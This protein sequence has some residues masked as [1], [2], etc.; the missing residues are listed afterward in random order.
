VSPLRTLPESSHA[1]QRKPGYR[2]VLR[3]WMRFHAGAQ[4][5][6]DAADDLFRAGQRNV[7]TLYE[8]WLFFQLLDWFC[9]RFDVAT[10]PVQSL[11]KRAGDGLRCALRQGMALGPFEGI[12]G[13]MRA[14]FRYNHT[15]DAGN[16]GGSWTR[17]MR[18]DFTL[19]F[20]RAD[21][22]SAPIHLHFDAKYRVDKL[23]DVFDVSVEDDPAD[24][25]T[26]KRDDLLKMH[27]Y[28]DAIRDTAGAYVLY[29]GHIAPLL[30]RRAGG[31]LPSLG[32]FAVTPGSNGRAGGM[33]QV[34]AFLDE[35]IRAL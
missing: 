6:W 25:N 1:L 19:T 7:A 14:Q 20:W 4:L 27:A 10:P 11:V 3:A 26:A 24:A 21:A 34:A 28:R 31:V 8:Y 16:P 33:E 9:G 18:P 30:L 35:V 32:A 29:P 2:D 13:G 17:P 22:P 12:A 5:A 23:A 15:F